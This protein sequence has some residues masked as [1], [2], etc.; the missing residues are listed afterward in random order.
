MLEKYH[1]EKLFTF[2]AHKEKITHISYP[3]ITPNLIVTSGSD[4]RVKLFS[5]IDGTYI[6]EF[7]QSSENLREYPIGL[8]YYFSDPFV[9]KINNDEEIKSSIVYRKDIV[10]FKMNKEIKEMNLMKKEHRPLNEYLN[11]LINLNAKER[12]YL[13]TKNVDL[14]LEKSSN[15]KYNPNLE[16]IIN[17]EKKYFADENIKNNKRY[18]FHLIDTKH[19]YPRFIKDMNDQQIKEFSTA[20]NNKIRRVKLTMAKVQI[21]AERYKNYEKEEKKKDRNISLKN[22]MKIIYGKSAEKKEYKSPKLEQMNTERAYNFG[23]VKAYKNIGERFDNYKSDFNMK[24]KDLENSFETKLLNRYTI[25]HKNKG[26]KNPIN[27]NK[28]MD[29]YKTSNNSLLPSINASLTQGNKSKNFG[30]S[31]K[32]KKKVDFNLTNNGSLT[33]REYNKKQY[34]DNVKRGFRRKAW[35]RVV[36]DQIEIKR[37]PNKKFQ[38]YYGVTLHQSYKSSD[39]SDEGYLFL[40]WDFRDESRPQIHVRT[41]QPDKYGDGTALPKEDIISF[42]DFGELKE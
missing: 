25:T 8:K 17:K 33:Y 39:Y 38:D 42:G 4:R 22:Q 1:I 21:D 40:L 11:K 32:A 2:E 5:A 36:F 20:L 24:L 30:N 10:G 15:W 35:I 41:W 3:D 23:I 16:E 31:V 34:L 18:D 7:I 13:I 37:H 19:Y 28:I 27:I 12:L 26:G 9:S 14:P 6:D 29:A